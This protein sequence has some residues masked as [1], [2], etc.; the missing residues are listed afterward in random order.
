MAI[1]PPYLLFWCRKGGP[2]DSGVAID[3]M[4]VK[5][6]CGTGLS[7]YQLRAAPI[8]I[9]GRAMD[10]SRELPRS[11]SAAESCFA[12]R[13]IILQM[14]ACIWE[15]KEVA[16]PS[17]FGW[18]KATLMGSAHDRSL[19]IVC[20]WLW[21]SKTV[22]IE[23]S[24]YFTDRVFKCKFWGESTGSMAIRKCILL[25]LIFSLNLALGF[26]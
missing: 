16:I 18:H 4:Y 14:T 15:S 25:S 19:L 9:C 5:G 26:W 1:I 21:Q 13:S 23:V 20:M 8:S 6:I 11:A 3:G 24:R 12:W 22:E 17:H 7:W 10:S 2:W